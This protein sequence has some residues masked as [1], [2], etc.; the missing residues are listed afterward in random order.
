M[1]LRVLCDCKRVRL[2]AGFAVVSLMPAVSPWFALVLMPSA[3]P[4]MAQEPK[5]V[6]MTSAAEVRALSLEAAAEKRPVRLEAVVGFIDLPNTVFIQDAEAG[7]FFRPGRTLHQLRVG[8]RVRLEGVTHAGLYL[9]GIEATAFE[10]IGHGAPPEARVASFDDLASGRWHYQRVKVQGV[11]RRAEAL[12]ETRAVLSLAMGRQIIDVRVDRALEEGK[13][14]ADALVEVEGLAAGGINERRQ[15]VQPYLRVA[16]WPDVRVLRSPLPLEEVPLSSASGLLRF[17]PAG[18]AGGHLHRVRLRGLVIAVFADGRVFLRDDQAEVPTAFAVRMELPAPVLSVGDRAE[19]VGFPEMERFSARLG[20]ARL[21]VVEAGATPE[22]RE[23]ELKSVVSDAFDAELVSLTAEV[24]E[25][26]RV[27]EGTGW[28]LR[29]GED[30]LPAFLMG[31]YSEELRSGTQVRVTAVCEVEGAVES[32]YRALPTGARLLLRSAA[33]LEILR[34]P[35]WWTTGRLLGLVAA[36]AGLILAG[37]VWIGMLRRQVARQARRLRDQ[38]A[39]EAALDER[40][41]I[42]REFHDTLEQELAGLSIRLG[43]MATRPMDDKARGLL[44]TSQH[45]LS[46]VQSEAHDLVHRLREEV[47]EEGVDLAEA[48]RELVARQPLEGPRCEVEVAEDLPTLPPAV[49]HHLRMIAQESLT[50]ALKHAQATRIGIRLKVEPGALV[51]T[52][53]D[54]G[55]GFDE[56]AATVAGRFGRVGIRERCRKIQAEATWQSAPGQGTV[57]MVRLP[58]ESLRAPTS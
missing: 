51:L 46:R 24:A 36:L 52:V 1:G 32:G 56:A 22:P 23:V 39:R 25:Q 40:H 19:V 45:L 54:N 27:P 4:L 48:L 55:Q 49:A 30:S 13:D 33:D 41:R 42:A 50:N 8:D 18:E 9:T 21:V 29:V 17:Q 58:L 53:S 38:V 31:G 10:V 11:V 14:W 5:G 37:L 7:T 2:R 3:L 12:D 34:A 16:D 43:A 57:V 6:P 28:R 35:S 26:W 44:D 47:S 20:D 15:L